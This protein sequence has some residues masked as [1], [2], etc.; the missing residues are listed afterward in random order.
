M[1]SAQQPRPSLPPPPQFRRIKGGAE[2]RSDDDDVQFRVPRRRRRPGLPGSLRGR[3][4]GKLRGTPFAAKALRRPARCGSRGYCYYEAHVDDV[5]Y[6][7]ARP[8]GVPSP[9][10]VMRRSGLG[11]P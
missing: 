8:N 3:W 1:R 9:R 2:A 10:S 6:G 11:Y 4:T 7:P 5:L